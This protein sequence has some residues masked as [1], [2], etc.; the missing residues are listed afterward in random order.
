MKKILINFPGHGEGK[1]FNTNARDAVLDPFIYLRD[2]L[3]D[4]GYDLMTADDHHVEDCA[5]VWFWDTVNLDMPSHRLLNLARKLKR[6]LLGIKPAPGARNLY[7]EIVRAGLRDRM[8]LFTGEPPAIIPRNWD[9]RA[10]RLFPVIFTWNDSYVDGKKFYKFHWPL[11]SRFPDI[12]DIPFQ[13]RKLLVNISG[14][15]FATH[16]RE[17]YTARRQTIR[18]FEQHHPDDFDLYG[19][20][21]D[22][23][24]NAQGSY[25][26]YRGILKNKWDVYP[27]Y[28][29][30][31]CYEN[32]W[33]EPG[34]ITEKIFDC[35]RAG[36]VPIYYGAPNI[37]D[38][39]DE[40]TFIDRQKFDSEADLADFLFSI[41]ESDFA[42]YRESIRQYLKSDKFAMFL[43]PA[44][45]DNIIHVLSL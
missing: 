11:A 22:E 42:H 17:L 3:K 6:A 32:M 30:G 39:V 24:R 40:Q 4:I 14:N 33:G 13:R 29:F 16:P 36:V 37:T 20:G 7:Q 45:A 21:W 9:A 25:P 18:Y 5:W 2:R 15:K 8:V 38:F 23:D 31:V 27:R 41:T 28:R 12:E 34:W 1:L 44:F 43:P 10:H 35:M 26:S 19:V